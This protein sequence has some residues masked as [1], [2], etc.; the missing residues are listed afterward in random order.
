M[1]ETFDPIHCYCIPRS[2]NL[3]FKFG[4]DDPIGDI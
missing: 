1:F 4:D 2:F 3:L